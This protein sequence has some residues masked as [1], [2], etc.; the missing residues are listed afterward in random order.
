MSE[1]P[2]YAQ[3]QLVGSLKSMGV[4]Y[5]SLSRLESNKEEAEEYDSLSTGG[6]PVRCRMWHI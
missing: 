2:L 3:T 4:E 1:V 6:T 5:D